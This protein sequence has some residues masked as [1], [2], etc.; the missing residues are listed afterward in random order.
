MVEFGG[1]SIIVNTD[2]Q[3]LTFERV[4]CRDPRTAAEATVTD[5]V[6]VTQTVVTDPVPI[7]PAI[8]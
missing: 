7:V 3:V 5:T 4:P 8:L 6:N 2:A 1:N